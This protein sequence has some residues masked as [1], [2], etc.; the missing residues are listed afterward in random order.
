MLLLSFSSTP[1]GDFNARTS[2]VHPLVSSLSYLLVSSHRVSA[3][4]YTTSSS[5]CFLSL[6]KQPAHN[7]HLLSSSIVVT[8]DV[9]LKG[10]S[11]SRPFSFLFILFN[12]VV[13]VV[14]VVGRGAPGGVA[15]VSL[16]SR[17]VSK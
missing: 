5:S 3:C 11:L 15:P 9:F 4:M 12:A 1:Q 14:V 13:V 16:E 17:S 2:Q 8:A 6:F 10:N 7:V